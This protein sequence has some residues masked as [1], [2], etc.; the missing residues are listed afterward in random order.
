[1]DE[2]GIDDNEYYSYG[3]SLRGLRLHAM[4]P[5]DRKERLNGIDALKKLFKLPHTSCVCFFSTA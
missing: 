4:R 5:E 2:F 3:Y 1:M